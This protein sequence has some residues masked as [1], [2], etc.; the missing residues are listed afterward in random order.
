MIYASQR[1]ATLHADAIAAAKRLLAPPARPTNAEIAREIGADEDEFAS[2]FPNGRQ[3]IE[4]LVESSVIR[5]HDR[6]VQAVVKAP[7]DDP[8]AQF[9]AISDS[10]L[11]WAS[12]NPD[13]FMIV[14][15][16]PADQTPQSGSLLRRESSMHELMLR[17]L[18]QAQK[19][20]K[21]RPEIDP[22]LLLATMRCM[23][24]GLTSKMLGG[25]L[26]RWTG[27]ASGLDA[28]RDAMR[29]FL[30]TTLAPQTP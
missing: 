22:L 29:Q 28:A 21:L 25:N 10:Y 8:L 7:P 14:A 20:G 5:L 19:A 18:V 23:I 11:G 24:F 30:A 3:V 15:N 16:I 27:H 6:C 17:L 9:I 26:T 1:G 4:A 13:E 12:D 2:V